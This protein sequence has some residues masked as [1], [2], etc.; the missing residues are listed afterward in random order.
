MGRPQWTTVLKV[1]PGKGREEKGDDMN[2]SR[3]E[4][5]ENP[6]THP[7]GHVNFGAYVGTPA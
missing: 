7:A 2:F 4:G 3:S 5:S 6:G 1:G